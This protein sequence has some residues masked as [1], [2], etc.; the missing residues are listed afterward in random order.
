LTRPHGP[1]AGRPPSALVLRD[2][3]VSGAGKRLPLA[4]AIAAAGAE[5]LIGEAN[6][7]PGEEKEQ[8]AFRSFGAHCVEVRWDPGIT[9]LRVSRIV[10]VID[11]GRII[12][13]KTARNQIEGALVMGV[14]MA[15]L[16]ESI[17]DRRDGHVVNDNLADYHVPVHADMPELDVTLLDEPD[18]HIGD[19]GAKG[20]GEIGIT[21]IAAAVA[22]A[23]HHA[24]GKRIRDLPITIEKLLG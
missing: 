14:G 9:K 24:T 5:P 4:R 7:K 1:F 10:S 6:V 3:H 21:G 8:F 13:A 2:G 19:F 22:N 11:A 12:N 20:L 15:L 23:V 17:Y 18:P 16:E